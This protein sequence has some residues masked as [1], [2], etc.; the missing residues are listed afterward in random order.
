M[1]FTVWLLCLSPKCDLS[2]TFYQ[3]WALRRWGG[4]RNHRQTCNKFFLESLCQK[5]EHLAAS[6]DAV[7][8]VAL[9]SQKDRFK[10]ASVVQYVEGNLLLLVT[11]A[12]D[13]PLH[14]IKFSSVLFSSSWSSMLAVINKI[15]W[16][17]EV[18][19]VNCT[20]DHR[21]CCS[22]F[23]IE[24]LEWRGY[25]TVKNFEGMF[26]CFER[27]NERDRRTDR[28]TLHDVRHNPRL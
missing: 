14:T 12:S 11:S 20:V 16:C 6:D 5:L 24:K 1:I 13:S 19:A 2:E 8:Q 18:C 23:G 17:A 26:I 22:H 28:Q 25:L 10:L 4:R 27:I 3:V 21:S 9:L 15:H 7:L